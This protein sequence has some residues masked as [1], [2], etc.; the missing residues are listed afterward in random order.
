MAAPY[1]EHE[2]FVCSDCGELAQARTEQQKWRV[3]QGFSMH[4]ARC[5]RIE[6]DAIR[7]ADALT[8]LQKFAVPELSG[9]MPI[10]FTSGG[11]VYV[12]EDATGTPLYV[13]RTSRLL[14]DRMREH[15]NKE[16]WDEVVT[17][18]FWYFHTTD[19]TVDAERNLIL[20]LQ[21]KHNRRHVGVMR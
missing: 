9:Q 5:Y 2:T 12:L 6:M 21:P 14:N 19:E 8:I 11:F 7:R 4:C 3:G 18:N 10:K 20:S 13:G 16:W 17:L 1:V 15:R